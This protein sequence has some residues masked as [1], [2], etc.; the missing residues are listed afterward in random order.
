VAVWEEEGGKT[1]VNAI[2]P[3]QTIAAAEP[4]LRPIAEQVRAGLAAAIAAL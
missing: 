4:S 1:T 2:D 3:L